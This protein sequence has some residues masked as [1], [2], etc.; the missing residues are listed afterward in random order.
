MIPY[1]EDGAVTIYHGDALEVLPSLPASSAALVLT[2]PP[3][4]TEFQHVW[5]PLGRESGR[6]LVDGGSL[7]TLLGHFQMPFVIDAIGDSLRYWWICGMRHTA[8]PAKLPGKW[9]DVQWKPALWYVK[10]ARRD[11]VCPTDLTEGVHRDKRFHEWGQPLS[12]SNRWVGWLTHPG[13]LVVDPFMGGGTT[14]VSAK[15]QGRRA[16]GVEIEERYCEAAASRLTQE[17]LF[18]EFAA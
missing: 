12:W 1:Y 16:V 10:G 6:I 7:V 14:L 5:K 11:K 17:S 3:Y 4:P 15:Q 9:V 2:D 18:G 13:E 8:P